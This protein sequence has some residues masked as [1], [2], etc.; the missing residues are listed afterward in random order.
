MSTTFTIAGLEVPSREVNLV[1]AMR[2]DEA[3]TRAV[4]HGSPTELLCVLAAN[5][6]L[7]WKGKHATGPGDD[8][9]LRPLQVWPLHKF[10]HDVQRYG[11][12]VFLE[13]TRRQIRELDVFE[14]GQRLLAETIESVITDEELEKA[15]DPT[16]AE[17]ANSTPSTS[18][19]A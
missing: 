16:A 3:R 4:E 10:D 7:R 19:S 2:L 1:E 9:R 5:I 11:E 15:A 18:T 14:S 17:A 6:G 12:A 8:P 13:I